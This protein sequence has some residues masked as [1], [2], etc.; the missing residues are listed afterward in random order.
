MLVCLINSYAQF[1]FPD[2][3]PWH[4]QQFRADDP[5]VTSFNQRMAAKGIIM[6][7]S[8]FSLGADISTGFIVKTDPKKSYLCMVTTAHGLLSAGNHRNFL[9]NILRIIFRYQRNGGD[10]FYANTHTNERNLMNGITYSS[11]YLGKLGHFLAEC[12]FDPN[13]ANPNFLAKSGND[14]AIIKVPKELFP[15]GME[16]YQ[17]PYSRSFVPPAV[18]N[19][20]RKNDLFI[21]HH[22]DALPLRISPLFDGGCGDVLTGKYNIVNS[23]DHNNHFKAWYLNKGEISPGSSGAPLIQIING[24]PVAL[25][26]NSKGYFWDNVMGPPD[27]LYMQLPQDI[28]AELQ[29]AN[30]SWI[31]SSFKL[32]AIQDLLD[33]HCKCDD[34]DTATYK[35]RLTIPNPAATLEQ[36]LDVDAVAKLAASVTPFCNIPFGKTTSSCQDIVHKTTDITMRGFTIEPGKNPLIVFAENAAIHLTA[37]GNTSFEIKTGAEVYMFA[38]QNSVAATAAAFVNKS[39]SQPKE[40]GFTNIAPVVTASGQPLQAQQFKVYPSP[41]KDIINIT[42]GTY[43]KPYTLRITDITGNEIFKEHTPVVGNRQINI[44]AKIT[45][46]GTYLVQVLLYGETA[47]TIWK[48]IVAK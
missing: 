46:G 34:G 6:I 23:L 20:S 31:S 24:W 18:P 40:A 16:V 22:S 33:K 9:D 30:R 4:L 41:T 38:T 2:P 14:Y 42:P 45:S 32:A 44:A 19:T 43:H 28:R 39:A 13:N 7:R 21:L 26:I 8:F 25:A 47:P 29:Q 35:G 48:I 3:T 10:E 5:S 11:S 15:I 1:V 17:F 12:Q 36:T 27:P 37:N